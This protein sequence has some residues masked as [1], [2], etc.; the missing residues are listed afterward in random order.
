MK[1]IVDI[2]ENDYKVIKSN[3]EN[4]FTYKPFG[5]I[6]NGIPLDDINVEIEQ[7]KE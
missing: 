7:N 2:D 1:L 5:I 3:Y 6:A 4:G